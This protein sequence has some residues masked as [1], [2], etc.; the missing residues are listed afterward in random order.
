MRHQKGLFSSRSSSS[1]SMLARTARRFDH[2][3][4]P[5]ELADASD[6]F[7]SNDNIYS[8]LLPV[9]IH[10]GTEGKII[11]DLKDLI[12]HWR[13]RITEKTPDTSYNVFFGLDRAKIYWSQVEAI[14]WPGHDNDAAVAVRIAQ[15]DIDM[16]ED[17]ERA[18]LARF[19][20]MHANDTPEQI[21]ALVYR[22]YDAALMRI[23]SSEGPFYRSLFAAQ[24]AAAAKAGF[25]YRVIR[26]PA[27]SESDEVD[28]NLEDLRALYG[29]EDAAARVGAPA[30]P[31]TAAYTRAWLK[32]FWDEREVF[33][34]AASIGVA[35]H[36]M[37]ANW[38][39]TEP[40]AAEGHR[41]RR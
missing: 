1:S 23:H 21:Q 16:S 6:L 9:E 18:W 10:N 40:G 7:Q 14:S 38:Q 32:H 19:R 11:Y 5:I 8:M 26:T 27:P 24:S 15:R 29:A 30:A 31:F 3:P 13:T 33:L 4:M 22:E 41:A 39:H 35:A 25:P 2:D 37:L 36:A 20:Q 12:R 34:V 17:Q 28:T